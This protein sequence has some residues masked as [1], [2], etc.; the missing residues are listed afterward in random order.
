MVPVT[1]VYDDNGNLTSKTDAR[2]VVTTYGYDSL[3]RVTSR[4]YS[5][6]TPPVTVTIRC[7][8][9]A[10]DGSSVGFECLDPQLQRL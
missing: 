7:P 3:N 6:G 5:D 8:A 2:G 9:T 4:S 1:Y 10:E